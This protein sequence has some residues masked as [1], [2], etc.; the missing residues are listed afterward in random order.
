MRTIRVTGKGQIRLK[1]DMTRLTITLG[2]VFKEYGEALT[3]SA[4]DTETLGGLLAGLGFEKTDLKTVYFNV[5]TEYEGYEQNGEY[6]QR[7]VGYRYS[8]TLKLDF[9]SDNEKLGKVVYALAH[10]DI[11]PE[12][13]ISYTVKDQEAAKKELLGKAVQD[14]KEKAVVLADAS[15]VALKDIQRIDY[16]WGQL[17]FEARPMND[18]VMCKM[19]VAGS[20]SYDMAIEPD[21]IEVTD[22]VTVIWE[23]G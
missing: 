2:E 23:I 21:D 1:P 17:D 9:E 11:R 18:M 8:H 13:R 16:T 22:T 19:S 7:L 14:A 3:R 4:Q 15:G 5:N 10:S 20:E 6:K 12:F